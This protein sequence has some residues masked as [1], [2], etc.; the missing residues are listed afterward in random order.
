ML[1]VICL[2]R[3]KIDDDDV[4]SIQFEVRQ[5]TTKSYICFWSWNKQTALWHSFTMYDHDHDIWPLDIYCVKSYFWA[6]ENGKNA[7]I[8]C[9][10]T[11]EHK[12][13]PVAR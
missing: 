5:S 6:P 4:D 9:L 2:H 8:S 10:H 7:G 11:Y 12:I 13:Y 1:F 3:Q